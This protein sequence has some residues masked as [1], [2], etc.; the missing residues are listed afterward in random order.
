MALAPTSS[1]AETQRAGGDRPSEHGDARD[2]AVCVRAASKFCFLE[3]RQGETFFMDEY[4]AGRRWLP[5]PG[6][7]VQIVEVSRRVVDGNYRRVAEVQYDEP[8][9]DLVQHVLRAEGLY[10]D[11]LAAR[12]EGDLARSFSKLRE[13]RDLNAASAPAYLALADVARKLDRT[14]EAL[15]VLR[16]ALDRFSGALN[17]ERE[18]AKRLAN[19]GQSDEAV[20]IL[21]RLATQDLPFV[22][23]RDLVKELVRMSLK[24]ALHEGAPTFAATLPLLT[25]V[26]A[27]V[28][29]ARRARVQ[30]D[31][32]RRAALCEA[33][34]SGGAPRKA[35]EFL[36]R[37][38]YTIDHET[39]MLDGAAWNLDGIALS[40]KPSRELSGPL[41]NLPDAERSFLV[42]LFEKSPPWQ[43]IERF[44]VALGQ[45]RAQDPAVRA[46]FGLV[47][48]ED[49]ASVAGLYRQ[50]LVTGS[51]V[52]VPIDANTLVAD[53]A[54]EIVKRRLVEY[55]GQR[56]LFAVEVPVYGAGFFGREQEFRRLHQ[57]ISD[58]HHVGVFGLRKMGKT[59]FLKQ[60]AEVFAQD[61]VVYVD[62]Q[63]AVAV[64]EMPFL[65]WLLARGVVARFRDRFGADHVG[66]QFELGVRERFDAQPR[67]ERNGARFHQDVERVLANMVDRTSRIIIALDEIEYLLPIEQGGIPGGEE[68]FAWARGIYQQTGG[69]VV[70]V[71]AG[72]NPWVAESGRLGGRDNPMFLLYKELY[73]P[74]LQRAECDEMVSALGGRMGVAFEPGAL[75]LV[76]EQTGGHP[77]LTRKL[78]SHVIRAL[79]HP[80]SVTAIEVERELACF[81]RDNASVFDEIIGRLRHLFPSEYD[82]LEV[83]HDLQPTRREI[84]ELVQEPVEVALKHLVGYHLL[85]EG[86]DGRYRLRFELLRRWLGRRPARATA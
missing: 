50:G 76:Y 55:L 63:T 32:P 67:P 45:W 53:G 16:E 43:V 14:R 66:G 3:D 8:T 58:G 77:L 81:S 31:D 47:I 28:D 69:R 84:E 80:R 34:A 70:T 5:A 57:L 23:D 4:A 40:A 15:A 64:R 21:L 2:F 27:M 9:R 62:L 35:V 82:V 11:G 29:R 78:C 51:E 74:P 41:G 46:F 30:I 60:L 24:L 49:T 75:A 19:L 26:A 65:W 44:R 52:L 56:D 33:L 12:E 37:H 71:V 83:V 7:R 20:A 79:D 1:K 54:D 42:V 85:S 25:D 10:K 39:L 72:A 68:F 73:V 38:G 86:D 59:S 18:V 17:V 22:P 36:L 61:L 6:A 13:S 48:H